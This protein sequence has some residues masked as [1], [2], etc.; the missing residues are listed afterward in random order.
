VS[1]FLPANNVTKV[2]VMDTLPQPRETFTFE[3]GAYD[4]PTT[5]KVSF[6]GASE[7][8][9]DGEGGTAQPARPRAM[10]REP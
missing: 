6:S 7:P 1:A 3:K 2:M 5:T 9:G 8:A 10:D 4:K